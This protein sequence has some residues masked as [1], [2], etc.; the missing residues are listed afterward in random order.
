MT[1][2]AARWHIGDRHYGVTVAS[3]EVAITEPPDAPADQWPRGVVDPALWG[4]RQPCPG[5]RAN[6]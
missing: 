5:L 3:S 4:S 6:R 1:S 2:A